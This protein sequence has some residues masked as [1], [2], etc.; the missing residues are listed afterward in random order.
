MHHQSSEAALAIAHKRVAFRR[1]D[2][3]HKISYQ[4]TQENQL[5]GWETLNIQ[6]MLRNHCLAKSVSDAAIRA[7]NVYTTYKG[8]WYGTVV[9]FIE[10]WFPSTKLCWACGSLNDNLMLNDR[11]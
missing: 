7:P 10:R 11:E 9:Q 8:R 3:A 6:G 4:L 1:A 5:V 2:L